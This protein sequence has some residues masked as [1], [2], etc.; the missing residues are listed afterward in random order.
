[1]K[2]TKFPKTIYIVDSPDNGMVW[3]TDI[4]DAFD[5]GADGIVAAV[6]ELKVFGTLTMEIK[7][8]PSPPTPK[9]K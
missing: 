9:K 5:H 1:M 6:Y 7:L 8:K 3:E 4:R 2:K